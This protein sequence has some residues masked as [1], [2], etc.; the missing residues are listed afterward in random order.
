MV[1]AAVAYP[2]VTAVNESTG[3]FWRVFG[4]ILLTVVLLQTLSNW[5][6]DLGDYENGADGADRTDRMV[7]SGQLSPV[8]MKRAIVALGV[9]AFG[10]GLAAVGAA[11]WGTSLL[12]EALAMVGLGVLAIGAA[13]RYTAGKNPYGYRGLGDLMVLVFFGWVGVGGTAFLLAGEWD[14]AWLL[15]GTW[16]GLMS[17]AVLNLNNM[18]DHVK[19]EKAGKR[20]VVVAM[21][22]DRA[23]VYHGACFVIG[24]AAWWA[25]ALAVEPGQW[26][27][28]G[29]IAIINAFHFTHAW[30]VW[31]CEDPAAL[32]PELKRVAL[33]T[34]VAALFILLAQTGGAA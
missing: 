8:V 17:T 7:A 19:D 11:F 24:W 14:F 3:A 18:R 13:Y 21:G 32:D 16:T 15:P 1:G 10:C 4:L 12:V 9:L 5:A 20:T 27:G 23:K 2:R 25:F 30:R 26:R 28:M 34:A 22:W 6:N 33:S 29:W 31:R